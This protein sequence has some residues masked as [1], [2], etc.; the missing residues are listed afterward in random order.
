MHPRTAAYRA[1]IE[2]SQCCANDL[3]VDRGIGIQKQQ[4]LALRGLRAGITRCG[5]V[6]QLHLQHLRAMAACDG[7]RGVFAGIGHHDHF[8]VQLHG[9]RA[10]MQALQRVADQGSLVMGG[11]HEGQH[12]ARCV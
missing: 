3:R 4:V 1:G 11:N 5:D 2:R 12:G 9:L 7:G 6:A 8:M 10:G